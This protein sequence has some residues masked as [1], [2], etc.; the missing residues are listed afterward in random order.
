MMALVK[1]SPGPGL[2]YREVPVPVPGAGEAL[3]RVVNASV[4]GTDSIIYDW[5]PWAERRMTTL[6]RITGHEVAGVIESVGHGVTGY[7][8]GTRVSAE[9]HYFCGSCYQCRTGRRE[10]CRAMRIMGVDADGAFARYIVVP[11]VNLWKNHPDIPDRVASLQEPLGNA[12]DTV[13][14]EDVTGKW[15]LITGAGPMGL[16]CLAV[17][18]AAGAYRVIVTDPNEYRLELAERMGADIVVNPNVM[19][20]SGP[21]LTATSGNGVDVLLEISGSSAALHEALPLVT[22]GGRVSLLGI[23]GGEVSLRLNED[24]IFKKLRVY[25]ITGRIAFSTWHTVSRLLS[26]GQLDMAPLITH[27][28]HISDYEKAFELMRTGRCGKVVFGV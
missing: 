16:M 25:G 26:S 27:E 23:F 13:Q 5:E 9:S 15:V 12:V 3:V 17:A 18:K 24:V 7:T 21:V 2:T 10:V 19:P 4:C 11:A 1:E 14:A 8:P 22:P 20:L 28:F 6:P